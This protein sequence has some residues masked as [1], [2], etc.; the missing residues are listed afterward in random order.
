M[1]IYIKTTKANIKLNP[2]KLYM[3]DGY[4]VKELLKIANELFKAKN[5]ETEITDVSILQ[6]KNLKNKKK[7][8]YTFISVYIIN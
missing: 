2:K 3:A 8:K 6:K 1:K 5:L 4:A 7:N